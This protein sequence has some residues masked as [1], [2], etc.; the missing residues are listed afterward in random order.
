MPCRRAL[1]DDRVG[2]SHR[3]GSRA[4]AWTQPEYTSLDSPAPQGYCNDA[5]GPSTADGFEASV[6]ISPRTKS[7]QKRRSRYRRT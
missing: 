2:P 1:R 5:V 3:C 6:N 7:P 4:V